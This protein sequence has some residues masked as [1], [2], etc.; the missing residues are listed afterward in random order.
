MNP[1]DTSEWALIGDFFTYMQLLPIS[2]MLAIRPNKKINV[3]RVKGLKVLGRVS[4]HK[5]F[6]ISG[7]NIILCILKGILPFKMHKIIYFFPEN[8]IFF[9]EVS[10]VNS[11]RLGLP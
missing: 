6:Y 2:H 3:F 5:F 4:T 1:V 9:I 7:K 8:L 11:G 10:P